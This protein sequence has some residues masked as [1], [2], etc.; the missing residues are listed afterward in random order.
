MTGRQTLRNEQIMERFVDRGEIDIGRVFVLMDMARNGEMPDE[1]FSDNE[2][3]IWE[4]IVS[5]INSYE[6]FHRIL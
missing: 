3:D 4:E 2:R 1:S 5:V 6:E